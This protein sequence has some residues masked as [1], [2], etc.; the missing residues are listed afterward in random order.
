MLTRTDIKLRNRSLRFTEYLPDEEV[1]SDNFT[2][3]PSI[4]TDTDHNSFDSEPS[5]IPT[6]NLSSVQHKSKL[7]KQSTTPHYTNNK[8]KIFINNLNRNTTYDNL[9]KKL[10][11]LNVVSCK[12]TIKHGYVTGSAILND[13]ESYKTA[14]SNQHKLDLHISAYKYK[15][16]PLKF[17]K[18]NDPGTAY[19]EGFQAGHMVGHQQGYYQGLHKIDSMTYIQGM[20]PSIH[21]L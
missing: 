3:S 1:Q 4:N 5:D 14:I 19:R 12:I 7:T 20:H 6:I 21:M 8:Y 17:R 15:D 11:T 2:G 13:Y 9:Y 16:K 18:L 10:L